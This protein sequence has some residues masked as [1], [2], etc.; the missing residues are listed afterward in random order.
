M[1]FEP[2]RYGRDV[3]E[4]LAL[5]GDGQRFMPL[6]YG[7]CSSEEA[8]G[9]LQPASAAALFPNSR[10]PEAALSG[11]WLYFSCLDESH[12]V[13]QEIHTPEGSFWHGI[14][15][16]QEPDADN[17]AYWFRR[18]GAHPIFRPLRDRASE[19]ASAEP[20][21]GYVPSARWDPFRFIEFCEL[22]R[23]HPGS[24]AERFALAVQL[25]EWQLLFD[26]C[27]RPSK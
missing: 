9:R 6:A 27:A 1:N 26:Y 17:A 25:S 7:T 24:A 12:R 3:A 4:I 13:S 19:L 11:L 5:D 22:A 14:L 10:A 15:H 18:T 23:Q 16:R 21:S 2:G 20:D 8:R